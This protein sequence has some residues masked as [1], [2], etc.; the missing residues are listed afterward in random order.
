MTLKLVKLKKKI[1]GYNHDY[2]I[3]TQEFNHL[4][5]DNFVATYLATKSD[6]KDFVK[7]T[8][9]DDKL[10]KLI[11]KVTSKKRKPLEVEKKLTDLKKSL[12]KN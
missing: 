3:T 12:H 10:K 7:K 1:L 8:Y 11:K 4:T 5:A 9:F 2:Y 6:I